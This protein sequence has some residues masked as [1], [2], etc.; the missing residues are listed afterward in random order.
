VTLNVR[1]T[2]DDST[3]SFT[4]SLGFY[5]YVKQ[6]APEQLHYLLKMHSK[7]LIVD[8]STKAIEFMGDLD[9]Y[10]KTVIEKVF[11]GYKYT[12]INTHGVITYTREDPFNVKN[13]D[14][15][16]FNSTGSFCSNEYIES[17]MY[18]TDQTDKYHA[19]SLVAFQLEPYEQTLI[20]NQ[21]VSNYEPNKL[22]MVLSV[23]AIISIG[24]ALI[25]RPFE[26]IM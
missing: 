6:K 7:G 26:Y 21:A 24:Y 17:L 14:T 20:Y 1:K 13:N 19:V 10:R 5:E 15:M 16:L 22:F 2:Y 9:K 18:L 11:N 3:S 25:I 8:Y 12:K 23:M 4:H